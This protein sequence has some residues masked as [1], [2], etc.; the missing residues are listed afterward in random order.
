MPLSRRAFGLL[1]AGTLARPAFA[2]RSALLDAMVALDA[3]YVPALSLTS[4]A[5]TDAGAAPRA[6]AAMRRLQ[7]RWPALRVALEI[8]KPADWSAALEAVARQ[9]DAAAAAVVLSDW[10]AAHEALEPVRIT[11]LKA[12]EAAGIDYFVDRLTRFHEP[13]EVLALAGSRGTVPISVTMRA[14]IERA[15]AEARA[16][17]RLVEQNLPDAADY[18]MA[19]RR[20][21]QFKQALADESAALT[22]LSDALRGGDDAALLKGAQAIKPPFARAFTAFGA[23]PDETIDP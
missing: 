23:A 10:A 2:A 16:Q 7:G 20:F 13:M 8:R 21:A 1:A 5:Q 9:I 3:L 6:Q 22:S 14:E 15:F 11:L 17:W 18:R 19:P 4:A 12:R